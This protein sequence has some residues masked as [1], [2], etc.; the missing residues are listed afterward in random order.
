MPPERRLSQCLAC[1]QVLVAHGEFAASK[2]V[3]ALN[4]LHVDDWLFIVWPEQAEA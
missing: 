3:R 4:F 2:K 1:E